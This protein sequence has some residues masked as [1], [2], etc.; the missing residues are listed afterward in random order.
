MEW[1]K[2]TAADL[3]PD[4]PETQSYRSAKT[5]RRVPFRIKG[6]I[7]GVWTECPVI[8]YDS[9]GSRSL[10][11]CSSS[12]IAGSIETEIL[13]DCC[14]Q[15][16]RPDL[17]ICDTFWFNVIRMTTIPTQFTN[18]LCTLSHSHSNTAFKPCRRA[19]TSL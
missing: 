17:V 9:E 4:Q 5:R 11:A 1:Y 15:I 8:K 12:L 10:T 14:V 19:L 2:S 13:L 3:L 16:P 6:W 18:S 7:V